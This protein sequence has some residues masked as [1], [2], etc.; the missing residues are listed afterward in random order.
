[1]LSYLPEQASK[2]VRFMHPKRLSMADRIREWPV[3]RGQKFASTAL[4][5]P[6]LVVLLLSGCV[7]NR[8]IVLLQ[9]GSA[10]VPWDA[11]VDSTW[12]PKPPAF[13]LKPGDVIMVQ[14]DHSQIVKNI[15]PQAPSQDM[16]LYRAVQHPYLIGHTIAADG[17]INLPELGSVSV[18]GI[19]IPEAEKAIKAIADGY[20]SDAAVKVVL[21]NF[22]ISVIGEV[23]RPGRY[24][25]YD[26]QVSVLDGLAMA[27]DLTV[28]AD[29]SRIRI[30]R[31][32]DGT[33]HL[34]HIDLKDQ[35]ILANPYFYLQP[36][37]VV[38]VD[39]LKRR[40][41]SGRD[42]NNVI[43]ILAF[44]VSIVSVY[45]ALQR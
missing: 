18:G 34:Y 8:K 44:L 42:P 43:N 16:N 39:P 2:T 45:A 27:N 35:N 30:M 26:D 19:S 9:D 36:D 5:I 28:L 20:Y 38:I 12:S 13:A 32:R 21:L 14:I 3:F 25:V 40:Q 23:N 22:N 4:L 33:N 31:S 1:M 24:P 6:A 11:L 29:R 10:R 17:T 15:V 41:F 37:D 7:P